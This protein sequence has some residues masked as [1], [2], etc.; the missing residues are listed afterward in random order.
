[1][2]HALNLVHGILEPGGWL[3]DIHDLP[4]PNLVEVQTPD[5]IHKVGWLLDKDGF[6]N[7]LAAFN[8]L[9]HTVVEGL[10]TLEDE[11]TFAYN[12]YLDGV[13]ELQEWLAEWWTS[14]ILPDRTL[15]RLEKLTS[16]ADQPAK[17]VLKL[18]ARTTRLR[19]A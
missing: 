18:Q 1:M 5:K 19:A 3:V 16:Q 6:E 14:A 4:A 17:I 12:I 15:Q 10:F 2:V 9:A 7:E 13:D 11:R 8:A